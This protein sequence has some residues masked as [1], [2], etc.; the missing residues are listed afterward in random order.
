MDQSKLIYMLR[1]NENNRNLEKVKEL[2]MVELQRLDYKPRPFESQIIS[3]KYAIQS[4]K[5]FYLYDMSV[6]R[7]ARGILEYDDLIQEKRGDA[8]S[9]VIR[10]SLRMNGSSKF[11]NFYRMNKTKS[12]LK[13]FQ[14]PD[15]VQRT[16]VN[17]FLNRIDMSTF[18]EDSKILV[19]SGSRFLVF[20]SQGDFISGVHFNDDLLREIQKI[21][22]KEKFYKDKN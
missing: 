10:S 17:D 8:K 15:S 20:S 5:I 9:H 6:G 7:Y 13:I 19:K 18:I 14:M 3:E 11:V 1:R 2:A 4:S 12:F 21:P 22:N 16:L